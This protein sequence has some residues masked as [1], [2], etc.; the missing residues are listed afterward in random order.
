MAAQGFV[1]KALQIGVE[2]GAQLLAG[3]VEQLAGDVGGDLFAAVAVAN[4]FIFAQ[5]AAQSLPGK[6]LQPVA[7][8]GPIHFLEQIAG[9]FDDQRRRGIR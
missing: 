3:L 5:A 7:F 1:G 2:A 6:A 9:A 4:L 8:A